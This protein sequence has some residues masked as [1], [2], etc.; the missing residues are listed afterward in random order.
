VRTG[1]E[2]ETPDPDND[3]L[4]QEAEL[5]KKMLKKREKIDYR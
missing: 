4:N 1:C 3:Q 5:R 2:I